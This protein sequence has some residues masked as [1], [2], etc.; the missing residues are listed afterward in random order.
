MVRVCVFERERERSRVEVRER[1]EV[2]NEQ[3]RGGE[4]NRMKEFWRYEKGE[5]DG[6]EEK[7][8]F[9]RKVKRPNK[10]RRNDG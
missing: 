2:K 6:K 9:K 4:E 5:C 1:R 3:S 10:S 7:N 8:A